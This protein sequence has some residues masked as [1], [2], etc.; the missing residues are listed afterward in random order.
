MQPQITS[1]N[2]EPNNT[3]LAT[4]DAN[5]PVKDT[6]KRKRDDGSAKL[7][8]YLDVMERPSKT[9][10]WL[11][12][13]P[14]NTQV[15]ILN[16]KE[17]ARSA[18]ETVSRNEQRETGF[19]ERKDPSQ[20]DSSNLLL[21]A[22]DSTAFNPEDAQSPENP[23]TAQSAHDFPRLEDVPQAASDDDWLRSRTSRLLG[24]LDEDD[25]TLMLRKPVLEEDSH[26]QNPTAPQQYPLTE[27][28]EAARQ[29][30]LESVGHADNSLGM[31]T[32][33]PRDVTLFSG[34]L[35]I[36]NLAYSA[37][38]EELRDFF[39]SHN[40]GVIEEVGTSLGLIY[41]HFLHSM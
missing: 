41:H 32:A 10:S 8:E 12:P 35:F 9:K 2:I 24:L 22:A 33:D 31:R 19:K 29:A 1:A 14:L 7:Q 5:A 34:R 13:E 40:F 37:T 15:A 21:D 11:N 30:D 26:H 39:E 4:K 20:T 16:D 28:A 27:T 36:R 6:K 17:Q 3:L 23:M 18:L 25:E 38:A